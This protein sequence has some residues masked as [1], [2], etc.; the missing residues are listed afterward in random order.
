MYTNNDRSAHMKRG[1][2]RGHSAKMA[3][4]LAYPMNRLT[5]IGPQLG[6]VC[7]EYTLGKIGNQGIFIDIGTAGS[8][9]LLLQSLLLPAMFGAG[10]VKKGIF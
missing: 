7:L 8:I 4:A 3:P 5:A 2:S 6:S 10:P 9:T 1:G